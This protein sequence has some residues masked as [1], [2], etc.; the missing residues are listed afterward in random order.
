MLPG[1]ACLYGRHRCYL[2]ANDKKFPGIQ[3]SN[4]WPA[5]VTWKLENTNYSFITFVCR[6]MEAW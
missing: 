4:Y 1:T 5:A 2:L 3:Q 6:S